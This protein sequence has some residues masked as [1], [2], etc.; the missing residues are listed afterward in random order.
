[1]QWKVKYWVINFKVQ[2][3]KISNFESKK[4]LKGIYPS[5][6]SYVYLFIIVIVCIYT[7]Y[8]FNRTRTADRY[9]YQNFTRSIIL[10]IELKTSWSSKYREEGFHFNNHLNKNLT[11]SVSQNFILRT[12]PFYDKA[13]CPAN[14]MFLVCDGFFCIL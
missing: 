8:V 6:V 7:N 14:V 5:L 1:M 10:Y 2:K 4:F 12:R 11:I 13:F 3:L 9:D